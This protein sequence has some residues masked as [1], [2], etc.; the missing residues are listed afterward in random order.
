MTHL[1][2]EDTDV[3][4]EAINDAPGADTLETEEDVN[5]LLAD[6]DGEESSDTSPEA[7][8]EGEEIVSEEE[9]EQPFG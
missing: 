5:A 2:G 8:A 1:R 6:L 9:L 4:A 7:S 3:E